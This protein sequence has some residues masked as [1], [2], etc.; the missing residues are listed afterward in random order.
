MDHLKPGDII[1]LR[2]KDDGSPF[3][4][5]NGNYIYHL[6]FSEGIASPADL[7]R[8]LRGRA[9][10][11]GTGLFIAMAEMAIVATDTEVQ[12]IRH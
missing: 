9:G 8:K 5:D 4:S 11:V 10:V 6:T 2:T 7:D 1:R 12:F 3:I